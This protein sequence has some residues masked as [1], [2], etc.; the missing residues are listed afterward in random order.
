WREEEQ[1]PGGL[2]VV[3]E[4]EHDQVPQ[5]GGRPSADERD[6]PRE[7][8]RGGGDAENG[9]RGVRLEPA[10]GLRAVR[11]ARRAEAEAT[12]ERRHE[13]GRGDREEEAEE[14]G[15]AALALW[16][17]DLHTDWVLLLHAEPR[18]GIRGEEDV[19]TDL[20]GVAHVAR[21]EVVEAG[22]RLALD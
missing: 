20:G 22:G 5:P 13:E 12:A 3:A 19:R 2:G 17:C 10:S 1:V 7:E 6:E 8:R 4:H 21:D 9:E 16:R 18:V 14:A 15:P 11:A